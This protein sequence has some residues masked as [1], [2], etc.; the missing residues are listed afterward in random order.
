MAGKDYYEILGVSRDASQ[1]EIKKSLPKTV[2]KSITQILIKR[3]MLR[4][5]LKK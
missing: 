1:D 4:Q 3:R 5:S 2:K